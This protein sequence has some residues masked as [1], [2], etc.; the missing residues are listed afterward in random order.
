[1][2]RGRRNNEVNPDVVMRRIGATVGLLLCLL[3]AAYT[4]NKLRKMLV[5]RGRIEGGRPVTMHLQAILDSM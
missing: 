5:I 4:G 1:M 3:L 2:Q